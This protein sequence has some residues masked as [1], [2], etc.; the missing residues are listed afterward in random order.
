MYPATFKCR[1]IEN[2]PEDGWRTH[3]L[4]CSDEESK[5]PNCQANQSWMNTHRK[6]KES[7][8]KTYIYQK[9]EK[10]RKNGNDFMNNDILIEINLRC[11]SPYTTSFPATEN[12][13]V[14]HKIHMS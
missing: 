9:E 7:W 12:D 6:G 3:L 8:N 4:W 14:I 11:F 5:I 13:P 2:A 10:K 1:Q